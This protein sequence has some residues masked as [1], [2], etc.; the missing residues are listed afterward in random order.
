MKEIYKICLIYKI[1]LI[2]S[3]NFFI[4]FFWHKK[5]SSFNL[6][7]QY[8]QFCLLRFLN[9]YQFV[10]FA[11]HGNFFL[12]IKSNLVSIF[13]SNIVNVL[14]DL[15][16]FSEICVFSCFV[17]IFWQFYTEAEL[18]CAFCYCHD[19][20]FKVGSMLPKAVGSPTVGLIRDFFSGKSQWSSANICIL[21]KQSSISKIEKINFEGKISQFYYLQI[22]SNSRV[23]CFLLVS[24]ETCFKNHCKI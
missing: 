10:I 18:A 20:W 4:W 23:L 5:E 21:Y 1:L 3:A 22:L 2:L 6:L 7:S 9:F 11:F 8:S 19:A 14:W 12:F 17:V 15:W 16:I 24:V 13:S